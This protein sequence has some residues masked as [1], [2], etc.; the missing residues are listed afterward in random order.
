MPPDRISKGPGPLNTS[1]QCVALESSSAALRFCFKVRLQRHRMTESLKIRFDFPSPVIQAQAVRHLVAAVLKE[2]S[3]NGPVTQSSP[4]GPALEAL[5]QQCCVDG[6]LVRSACC[7]ALVLL[8]EQNHADLHHVLNGVLNLLPSARAG[9]LTS[10]VSSA[11]WYLPVTIL[12]TV[13]VLP[14]DSHLSPPGV[15]E[16]PVMTGVEA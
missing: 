3:V 6:A 15:E 12:P 11:F 16:D 7:D 8:V 10:G 9:A 14:L 5:W 2:I 1:R 13:N 4:Q